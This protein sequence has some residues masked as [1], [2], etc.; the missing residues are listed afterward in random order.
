MK[1]RVN[2]ILRSHGP[3]PE[4]STTPITLA[5]VQLAL[6]EMAAG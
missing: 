5:E 3:E 4:D 6:D 1:A 2:R